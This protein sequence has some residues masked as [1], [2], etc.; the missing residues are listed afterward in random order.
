MWPMLTSDNYTKW[1]MLMQCNYEAL[2]IWEVIEPGD[3]PK[4]AQDRQAMSALLRSVPKEMWQTLGGKKT[5]KDAWEAVKLMRVGADRVKE[6]NA[7]RILKEF[8]NIQFKE[9]ESVDDFG[10]RIINLVGNLKT[11]GETI[12]DERVVKKFLRVVPSRFTQI[13]VS[14]EMFVD[15]KKLTV[16]ELVGWLR[17]AEERLDDNSEQVTNKMGRLMLAEDVWLE[18]HKHR[19]H[20]GNKAGGSGGGG[21]SSKGKAAARQDGGAPGQVK[22][23]S[24]GTPRRK[25]RCRNCGI[26]GH[27]AEDCKRPKKEKKEPAQPEANVAVSDQSGAL[28]LATCELLHE[29]GQVVHMTEKTVPVDV[30]PGVWVL[31]TGASN[32][33]TGTRSALTNLNEGV[34]GTVRFGD[35]SRVEIEGICSVVMQGRQNQHKVLTNVYYIPKL[36]SNIVSLGQ[37]EENGLKCTLGDGKLCV[38]DQDKSLLIAAPRTANRLYTVKLGLTLPIC[39]LANTFDKDWQWHARYGHLNFKSLSELGGRQMVEGMPVVKSWSKFVIVVL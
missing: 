24:M 14:L 36:K 13:V 10:M 31:D 32:H 34:I 38:Y 15:L 16:E 7:Q 27:W 2:E 23:T 17:A 39:L 5:V 20:S 25:G 1:S 28:L 3:K 35:G 37:L 21:G 11:L 19:F 33:M 22:L 18:K 9:G 6:V 4:R 26:Y 29:P 12:S 30:P 8:E